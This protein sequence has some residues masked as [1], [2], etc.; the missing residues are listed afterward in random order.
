[1]W[2][3]G[4][5]QNEY[6]SDYLQDVISMLVTLR[7]FEYMTSSKDLEFHI[8]QVFRLVLFL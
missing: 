6:V 1:M 5:S 3:Q 8:F 7:W 4:V 2:N